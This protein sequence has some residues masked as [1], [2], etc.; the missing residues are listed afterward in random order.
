MMCGAH[1]FLLPT[2]GGEGDREAVEGYSRHQMTPPSSTPSAR[3]H[4]PT[5]GRE[6]K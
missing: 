2:E 4:L 5:F 3:C 1:K 6:E